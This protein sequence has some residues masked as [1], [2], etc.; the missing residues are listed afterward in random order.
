MLFRSGVV[1]DYRAA[2][3]GA[4]NR[5]QKA[6][7]AT[8]KT[9][10]LLAETVNQQTDLNGISIAQAEAA[11]RLALFSVRRD[12]VNLTIANPTNLTIDLGDV[13]NLASD[14]L[15]YGLGRLMLVTSVQIDYQRNTVDLRLWG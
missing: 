13:I 10:R 14:K 15:G 2:W 9:T 3:L 4:A 12:V 11:R 8:V 5:D 1:P 7:N 6:E